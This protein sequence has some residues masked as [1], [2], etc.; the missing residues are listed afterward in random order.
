MRWDTGGPP[1]GYAR[2]VC[3]VAHFEDEEEMLG[4]HGHGG[5]T[6]LSL[7][8][9]L[10][11]HPVW[12]VRLFAVV[13]A[14]LTDEVWWWGAQW[15]EDGPAVTWRVPTR[16][17]RHTPQVTYWPAGAA[18]ALG[19]LAVAAFPCPLRGAWLP[20]AAVQLAAILPPGGAHTENHP[21]GVDPL[22]MNG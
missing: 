10:Q 2:P 9:P 5:A 3:Q 16:Y 19:E 4:V 12:G 15:R 20:D 18:A 14:A 17:R 22:S 13:A 6:G 21:P 7:G 11:A 1:A 8:D